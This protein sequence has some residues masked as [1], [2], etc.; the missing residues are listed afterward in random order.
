MADTSIPNHYDAAQAA[1]RFS[2]QWQQQGLDAA[3]PNAEGP[4][5]SMIMP[6]PNVTGALHMGHALN[7]TLQDVL[8]RYKRM[9]GFNTVWI[10]GVDHASIAVH[11]LV[12]RELAKEGLDKHTIG[13]E[14][15]LERAQAFKEQ[16]QEKI[17]EQFKKLGISCDWQ[18]LAFTLDETR[19]KAVR[20]AFVQLYEDG[21]IYRAER[22]VNWDPVSQTTLSDLEVKHE[23]NVLGELFEFAYKLQDG[24][25]ELVVATTRPETMLAD[26]AVAVHPKDPRYAHL[27]GRTL[28]HPFVER[29]IPIVADAILVDPK[30]GTGV[31]KVTPAHDFN[32]FEVGQRHK[33]PMINMLNPDGTLAKNCGSFANMTVL[34]AR[35]AIKDKL[36]QIGLAR[37]QKEH[38]LSLG[39][40]ER[41]GAIVE[42]MLSTQW[43]V[44]TKPLAR[45]SLAVVENDATRFVPKNWENTYFSWLR[46]I[47]DWCISRQLWWGHRIP[48]WFCQDCEH[49]TVAR[50]D[51]SACEGCEGTRIVQETDI[52]DTWFSSALWPFS[53]MGWPQKT[54]DLARWYPT[55]TLVTG[56]DI[57]FFW[58]A[59]MMMFGQYF[60]GQAPFENVVLHALVR[61]AKGEKMSK[62]KGNVVNPL[63]MIDRYGCDAFRFTLIAFAAQGRDVRWD[64]ART[65]GYQKFCNKIWQAFRFAMTHI[66]AAPQ[67]PPQAIVSVWDRWILEEL[68]QTCGKV[69]D[70]LDTFR[71]N[72]AASAIY[73]FVWDT[74]CDWYL[75]LSKPTLYAEADTPHIQGQKQACRETLATV[76]ETVAKLMHPMM[77]FLSEELWAHLPQTQGLVAK[78]KYPQVTDFPNDTTAHQEAC[79]VQQVIGKIRR[80]RAEF[81][82]VPKDQIDVFVR[83]SKPQR[84]L[85]EAH[86]EVISSLCKSVIKKAEQDHYAHAATDSVGQAEILVPLAGLIDFDLE[87]KRLQKELLKLEKEH[88]R[89]NKQLARPDFLERAPKEIVEEKHQQ[90]KLTQERM[91][92]LNNALARLQA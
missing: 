51:P 74:F 77:P 15:F 92:S 81:G 41:S 25:G 26:T 38:R 89:I 13:R 47:R 86:A 31:V 90:Q 29:E 59:R 80:I 62:T 49:V 85:L 34:Q 61:D 22:L 2:S 30:F 11:W 9:D 14:K 44:R 39:R 72:D 70:A 54:A 75:E 6:P 8:I 3:N 17:V 78:T 23:E 12:E 7:A 19:I 83:A 64:D 28:R 82:V 73:T 71:F 84:V 16:S 21:L 56:F 45:P 55:A 67:D 46:D 65:Q 91:Q 63:E 32:D 52:L 42:P 36:E 66:Q 50:E 60:M 76:F 27:V 4:S 79:F 33:L 57:I 58:V 40:S 43:Y 10:P 53:T 18:R 68:R 48:A 69:R 87:A 37:G 5:Y 88:E 35:V 20:E 1:A 24:S